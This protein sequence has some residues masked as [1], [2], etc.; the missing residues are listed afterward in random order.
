MTTGIIVRGTIISHG[1]EIVCHLRWSKEY[2]IMKSVVVVIPSMKFDI[3]FLELEYV[4]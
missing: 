1:F 2:V 4:I 3:C